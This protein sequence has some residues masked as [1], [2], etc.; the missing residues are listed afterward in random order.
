MSWPKACGK[1][2]ERM[3][4]RDGIVDGVWGG[5]GGA[6]GGNSIRRSIAV[7]SPPTILSAVAGVEAEIKTKDEL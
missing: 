7:V 2:K 4:A 6:V 3:S 1:S 5:G